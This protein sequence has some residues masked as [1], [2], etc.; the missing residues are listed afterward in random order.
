MRLRLLAALLAL[1]GSP[2]AAQT[3]LSS[4]PLRVPEAVNPPAARPAPRSAPAPR[5]EPART[6]PPAP[7][8]LTQ[9]PPIEQGTLT[10]L[11]VD[12]ESALARDAAARGIEG[13]RSAVRARDAQARSITPGS[14]ALGGSYRMDT[15]GPRDAREWD[16]EVAAPMWLPGQRGAFAETIETGVAEQDQRLLLRRLE[17]AGQLREAYW[18]VA[19]AESEV[20]VARERL[21]TARDVGRDFQRRVA[22]GDIAET[23][24]L[25]ARNEELAAELELSRAEAAA[26][27]ARTAYRTLTGGSSVALQVEGRGGGARAEQPLSAAEHPALRAAEAALAN[28]E[29]RAKLVAATPRDNPE[30]GFFGRGQ[31][32]SLTEDGFSLGL[33]MR[34]PL[35]TEAR[36]APRRAEAEAERTRAEAELAQARR[37]LAG[38]LAQARVELDASEAMRRLAAARRSVADQQLA[39]ARSAFRN[40]EIGAFDLF[41]VR[42][43]QIEAVAGD[44]K[45]RIA[46]GRARSRL[47]QAVGALPPA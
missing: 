41:R 39:A 22:L 26:R 24:A 13:A 10:G 18:R 9:P 12:L 44:A 29:A 45:A 21:A 14:P 28:A 20:G 36:N 11:A 43:L 30:L 34:L 17:L 4:A 3:P 23:E 40:G 2:A 37:M 6:P 35:S 47:N 25:L 19:E 33:R 46:V 42:Q 27:L 32:G 31:Y 38:D 5:R 8:S 1:G 16:V 7:A 15:R